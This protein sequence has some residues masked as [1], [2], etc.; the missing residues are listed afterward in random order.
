MV[1]E[2]RLRLRAL[3]RRVRRTTRWRSDSVRT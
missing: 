2:R 1:M 3:P